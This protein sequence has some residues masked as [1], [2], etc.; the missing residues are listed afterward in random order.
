MTW[1][2]A[3]QQGNV[4]CN[5]EW[6]VPHFWVFRVVSCCARRGHISSC[7]SYLL[8]TTGSIQAQQ[9]SQLQQLL[10]WFAML[11]MHYQYLLESRAAITLLALPHATSGDKACC[12]WALYALVYS[13]ANSRSHGHAASSRDRHR[14]QKMRSSFRNQMRRSQMTGEPG[15]QNRG[16]VIGRVWTPRMMLRGLRRRGRTLQIADL[17]PRTECGS[18]VRQ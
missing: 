8:Y 12:N 13:V 7:T 10:T 14:W 5:A 9:R 15:Y 6:G 18:F 3:R 16:I 2:G 1:E 17:K 11:K 4:P